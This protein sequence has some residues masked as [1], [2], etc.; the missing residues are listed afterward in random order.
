[1][2]TT[3]V[4]FASPIPPSTSYFAWGLPAMVLAVIGSDSAWPCL[5]L[6]T[7]KELPPE[8]QAVGGA[9]VNSMGQL[10][11]AIGLAIATS[12]QTAVMADALDIPV[13]D[14]ERLEPH[15]PV[16]LKGIR[17]ANWLNVGFV[18]TSL[19]LVLFTFRNMDIIGKSARPARPERMAENDPEGQLQDEEARG[20]R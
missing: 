13:E 5:M 10:G 6:S 20:G 18:V 17:G 3:V 19:V 2:I 7:S 8:D 4:L 15:H 14:V 1:M 11:R 9:L 16:T 12:V